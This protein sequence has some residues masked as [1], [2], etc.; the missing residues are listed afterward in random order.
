MALKVIKIPAKYIYS[1]D[2]Q[3]VLDN[4]VDKIEAQVTVP[5]II[6]DTQN[7]YNEKITAGF[8]AGSE[9]SDLQQDTSYNLA[10]KKVDNVTAY[11]QLTPTYL[12]KT[13]SVP[14][15]GRNLYVSTLL[16]GTNQ[17]GSSNIGYSLY[18]ITKKGTATAIA[19]YANAQNPYIRDIQTQATDTTEGI[20]SILDDDL[21]VTKTS[22]QTQSGGGFHSAT[23][24]ITLNNQ[25]NILT[26][27]ATE[28]TDHFVITL[29]FLAGIENIAIGGWALW[30]NDQSSS[31]R[32]VNMSGEYLQ[33]IPQRIN[34]SLSGTVLVLDIQTNNITIGDGDNVFS[35]SGNELIQT[36]LSNATIEIDEISRV[37][38]I[39]Q[40]LYKLVVKNG[41]VGLMDDIFYQGDF[42]RVYEVNADGT[43]GV[44][45]VDFTSNSTN[46]I[47][48]MDG[49]G[50]FEVHVGT[51][52]RDIN[53]YNN[54]YDIIDEWGEGKEL[55]TVKCSMADYY[56]V[57]SSDTPEISINGI[58]DNPFVVK[59]YNISNTG[60]LYCNVLST[61]QPLKSGFVYGTD[62]KI[63]NMTVVNQS[64][65]VLGGYHT[66]YSIGDEIK[67]NTT[68]LKAKMVFDIDEVVL[69]YI[70]NGNADKYMSEYMDSS[71]K[72]FDVIGNR[73]SSNG[74]VFQTLSLRQN[75]K[76]LITVKVNS[77]QT[78]IGD[79]SDFDKYGITKIAGNIP[80]D[81][82]E[83]LD[84]QKSVDVSYDG[85]EGTITN[86]G[87]TG[88]FTLSTLLNM[89]KADFSAEVGD[90]L[91]LL[92]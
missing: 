46:K 72:L 29:T 77:K 87:S 76:H 44:S 55:A 17:Y 62:N 31:T 92:I 83:T 9:Q 35:L 90:I 81:K 22:R 82:I 86:L 7:V 85:I 10:Q 50:E 56:T 34:I 91:Y 48:Q 45:A 26:A 39:G 13:I 73:I 74:V 63:Y 57:N 58:F 61:S 78:L 89:P 66:N 49:Q 40:T 14:K 68:P 69:P 60:G 53:F 43:Y 12:T 25:E 6:S 79:T 30:S 59:I 64:R 16:T 42:V 23:A 80:T 84:G 4:A 88:N 28:Y 33:Y 70:Y 3:K 1:I 41:K 51:N 67:L 20:F 27:T 54:T 15:Q 47:I 21:T 37:T 8:Y 32:V 75:N 18:G 38:A 52:N 24:T 11:V 2:N 36:N 65:V 19:D 5:Q 71:P